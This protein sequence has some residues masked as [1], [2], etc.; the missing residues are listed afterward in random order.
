[1]RSNLS[2]PPPMILHNIMIKEGTLLGSPSARCSVVCAARI[3]DPGVFDA[4]F[5]YKR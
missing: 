5:R 4:L 2:F 3:Q 1:M